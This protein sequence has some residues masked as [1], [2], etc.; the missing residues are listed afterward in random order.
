[1][2]FEIN[3]TDS[4]EFVK[5][6]ADCL[7]CWKNPQKSAKLEQIKEILHSH[8]KIPPKSDEIPVYNE[9]EITPKKG[10]A[11]IPKAIKIHKRSCGICQEIRETMNDRGLFVCDQC[12]SEGK[13][14][15]KK[16]KP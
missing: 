12:K 11:P 6:L 1:M 3:E 14:L 15:E 4:T 8:N 5:Y 13:H 9:D 16:V 10:P 2:K 7:E